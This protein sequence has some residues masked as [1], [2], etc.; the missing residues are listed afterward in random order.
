MPTMV[1]FLI[2]GILEFFVFLVSTSS[3]QGSAQERFGNDHAQGKFG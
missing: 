3:D 2:E 1:T